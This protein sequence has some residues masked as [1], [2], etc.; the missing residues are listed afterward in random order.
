V[1]AWGFPLP[2]LF[3]SPLLPIPTPVPFTL[4]SLLP[5]H[6][7]LPP[8]PHTL[9]RLSDIRAVLRRSVSACAG[10]RSSAIS[11]SARTSSTKVQTPGIQSPC[12]Q[13]GLAARDGRLLCSPAVLEAQH[14][15]HASRVQ[16]FNLS[17]SPWP[18]GNPRGTDFCRSPALL[19]PCGE[20]IFVAHLHN[21]M[22]LFYGR[23][24]G[25]RSPSQ[26]N[27]LASRAASCGGSPAA[28]KMD[29][30]TEGVSFMVYAKG[31]YNTKHAR[32]TILFLVLT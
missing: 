4:S 6:P 20:L 13:E 9:L 32:H 3:L 21:C 26:R 29:A 7:P 30:T 16:P 22:C 31:P 27:S 1:G 25:L 5:P 11:F 23:P 15:H 17:T 10:P 19:K 14:S 8:S 18:S 12:R 28:A 2:S 24:H